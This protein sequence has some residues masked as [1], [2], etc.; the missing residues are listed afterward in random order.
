MKRAW[1]ELKKMIVSEKF[2]Q[3]RDPDNCITP[4]TESDWSYKEL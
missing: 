2:W 1:D 3:E 4:S